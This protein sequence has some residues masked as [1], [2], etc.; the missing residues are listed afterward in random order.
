MAP[1]SK[2]PPAFPPTRTTP[3]VAFRRPW[4]P[5]NGYLRFHPGGPAQ[6]VPC[7]HTCERARSTR[8][9]PLRPAHCRLYPRAACAASEV[10]APPAA[11]TDRCPANNPPPARWHMTDPAARP[12][13][14]LF[15]RFNSHTAVFSPYCYVFRI[16]QAGLF[17]P[18]QRIGAVRHHVFCLAAKKFPQAAVQ[19]RAYQP[20][21]L[22]PFFRISHRETRVGRKAKCGLRIMGKV[23]VYILHAPFPHLCRTTCSV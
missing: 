23:V 17:C 3:R 1:G 7:R 2:L 19:R 22:S 20:A 12:H 21:A 15:P 4:R 6:D 14:R 8:R 9:G 10:P 5:G 16:R 11:C 18:H 13:A